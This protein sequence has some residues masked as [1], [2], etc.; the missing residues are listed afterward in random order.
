[1]VT[2]PSTNWAR[3]GVATLIEN[4]ALPLSHTTTMGGLANK[5]TADILYHA[6]INDLH[7]HHTEQQP[8]TLS[9]KSDLY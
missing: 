1:M 8:R 2:E 6:T 3:R 9:V 7:S 5:F 4:N